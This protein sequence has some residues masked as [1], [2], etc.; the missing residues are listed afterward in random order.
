MVVV[1]NGY[2]AIFDALIKHSE[3]FADRIPLWTEEKILNSELRGKSNIHNQ[4]PHTE[5]FINHTA[6]VVDVFI[7]CG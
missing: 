7:L 5:T 4:H 6:C 1:L 3:A 2:D